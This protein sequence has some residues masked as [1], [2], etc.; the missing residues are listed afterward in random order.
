[1]KYLQETTAW[2]DIDYNIPSHIYAVD[3]RGWCI[4]YIKAG[5]TDVRWFK[6]PMK[7]FNK[8]GRTFK[9]VTKYYKGS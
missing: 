1:M 2:N 5:T 8:K 9:D 4:G 6:N 7:T 3:G